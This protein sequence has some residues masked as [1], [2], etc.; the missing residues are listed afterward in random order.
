VLFRSKVSRGFPSYAFIGLGDKNG[1]RGRKSLKGVKKGGLW[2]LVVLKV[3][4][5][6]KGLGDP[7][8]PE[9]ESWGWDAGVFE[10]GF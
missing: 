4:S 2:D 3:H 9:F 5:V 1:V 8:V 7:G 6:K 10:P